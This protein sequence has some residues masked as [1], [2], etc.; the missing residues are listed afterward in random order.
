[1]LINSTFYRLYQCRTS[2][3]RDVFVSDIIS[4]GGYRKP[5]VL[6]DLKAKKE[7]VA[8]RPKKETIDKGVKSKGGEA[9]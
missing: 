4:N 1:M 3:G 5:S 9:I 2:L 8:K 7:E 6:D